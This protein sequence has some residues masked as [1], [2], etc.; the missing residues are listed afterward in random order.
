[1]VVETIEVN[2]C[3]APGGKII[4]NTGMLSFATNDNELAVGIEPKKTDFK[5][6]NSLIS[7]GIPHFD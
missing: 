5:R 6:K 7:L 1:V 3:S 2:A 4:V